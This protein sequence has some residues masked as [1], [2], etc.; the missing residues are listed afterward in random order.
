M[1][2]PLIAF[3]LLFATLLAGS[4]RG[5]EGDDAML[6]YLDDAAGRYGSLARAIWEKAEVGYQEYDSSGLLQDALVESGFSVATGVADIPTAFIASYGEG[7]PV[8]ALLAEFDALPGI[9]Q[10]DS[11]QREPRDDVN[12]GHACGHHLFGA[13]S[14]AAAV[15]I[16]QWLE[17]NSVPGTVR[18]YGT[19]AEEGGSGKVYMVRAGLFDDVDAVLSWH[20]SDRNAANPATSLA[21][22]SAKFRYRGISSHAAVAPER[23]RSSLD[24][25]EAMNYMVNMMREHVPQE[26]RIHY[27]ITR[28]GSAPNVVPDDAEVFY[29]LRHPRRDVL[30]GLWDR[31]M[32]VAEA[33]ALGTGT[34]LEYEVI[35]GNFNKLPNETLSAIM[36]A[37]LVRVGGV[38]YSEEEADFARR[39]RDSLEDAEALAGS[40]SRVDPMQFEQGMGSTDV[41]DVSWMAPTTEMRAATWVPG[42]APHS[43]QAIASGGTSIGTKGM[44]VAAKTLALTAAELYESPEALSAARN[45]FVDRRGEDFD[46]TPLLGDRDPPLDYRK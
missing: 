3:S 29:Y 26:T 19:P 35:H 14:V 25:V 38:Q 33:A 27:V 11:P 2:R 7:G 40:E 31:V 44:L 22:K 36:H 10:T 16:K 20:P 39:L 24:A 23:G 43:W 28:G 5:A 13:G 37:N 41:G 6:A 45:E 32:D 34:E 30:E 8:I 4:A 12:A 46:Y 17:K 42:T 1:Q 15:A 18:L 21:N 9:T